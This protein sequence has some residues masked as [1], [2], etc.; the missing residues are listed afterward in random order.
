MQRISGPRVGCAVVGVVF[1]T[2]ALAVPAGATAERFI[3]GRQLFLA[4]RH[5]E[6]A[7][8]LRLHVAG[9]PQDSAAWIWLGAAY[10]RLADVRAAADAF[11]RAARL[12]PSAE[13]AV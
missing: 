8:R 1:A 2:L 11:G 4:G 6:A 10:Y 13:V 9:H 5:A 3:E 7:Q 12:R